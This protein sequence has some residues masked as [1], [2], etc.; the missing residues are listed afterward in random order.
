MVEFIR[1]F[2]A[3]DPKNVMFLRMDSAAENKQTT[4]VSIFH[5]VLLHISSTVL[6]YPNYREEVIF[7]GLFLKPLMC[8]NYMTLFSLHLKV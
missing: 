3:K 7:G 5:F 6:G 4:F 1:K 2:K 8:L